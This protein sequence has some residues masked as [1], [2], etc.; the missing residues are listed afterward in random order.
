MYSSVWN[1]VISNAVARWGRC[2]GRISVLHSATRHLLAL[3]HEHLHPFVES[4][5][6]NEIV[7]HLYAVRLHRVDERVGV[8][9]MQSRRCPSAPNSMNNPNICA[10]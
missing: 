2:N 1:F 6:Y 9:I 7:S 8:C 4:V 3:A 10:H 5:V